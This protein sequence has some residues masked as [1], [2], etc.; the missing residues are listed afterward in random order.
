MNANRKYSL[1]TYS[2]GY[3]CI[4]HTLLLSVWSNGS[5]DEKKSCRYHVQVIWFRLLLSEAVLSKESNYLQQKLIPP[6]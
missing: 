5:K 2:L 6:N 3:V 1:S 4:T